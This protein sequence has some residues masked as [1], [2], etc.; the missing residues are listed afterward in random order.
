MLVQFATVPLAMIFR[1]IPNKM[2][3]MKHMYSLSVGISCLLWIFGYQIMHSI[4]CSCFTY[5][6]AHCVLKIQ[7]SAIKKYDSALFSSECL[8][9][10]YP[11]INLLVIFGYLVTSYCYFGGGNVSESSLNHLGSWRIYIIYFH[12]YY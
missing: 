11:I 1:I 2:Y 9:N 6:F 5:I 12:V 4:F 3:N 7:K 8:L 10:Y